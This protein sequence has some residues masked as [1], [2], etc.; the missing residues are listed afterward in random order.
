MYVR[1]SCIGGI[2]HWLTSITFPLHPDCGDLDSSLVGSTGALLSTLELLLCQYDA[3]LL[4]P[5]SVQSSLTE[6]LQ[7]SIL[8]LTDSFPLFVYSMWRVVI[9]LSRT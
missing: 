5:A 6:D 2:L 7:N 1:F 4:L 3:S 8:T 9:Q